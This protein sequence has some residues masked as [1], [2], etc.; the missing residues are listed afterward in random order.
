MNPTILVSLSFFTCCLFLSGLA[1]AQRTCD[2]LIAA[3]LDRLLALY[4]GFHAAP[5]L[6][7]HEE[8]SAA[9]VAGELRSLGFTV[10]ERVGRYDSKDPTCF[11]V[12]GVL[13]NGA[14]PTVLV[15]AD[16]DALPVTEMTGLPYASGVTV[17]GEEGTETGLMHACGHDMHMTC[18]IGT[19]RILVALK[20]AWRGTLIMVAQPAE[21]T[22]AGAKAML[23][24]GLYDRFGRPDYGLALHVDAALAAGTVGCSAGYAMA[25]VDTVDVTVR[26]VGGHGAYPHTTKD[27]VVM[28]AQFVLNLQT[29][30]SREVS[31][32]DTAVVTVGSIHGGTKHNIIPDAVHLQLTVR[33]YR[34][35]VRQQV[36]SSLRRIAEGIA[37]G[38]GVPE[39]RFPTVVVSK[40]RAVP[41]LYNDP[42]LTGRLHKAWRQA[43]GAGNVMEHLPVMA[44]EDF[45]HYSLAGHEIPTCLFWLGAVDPAKV[46]ASR[47]DGKPLPSLHSPFFAPT[48]KPTIRTGIDAMASAVL[49]LL[50]AGA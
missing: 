7:F 2:E 45:A 15:R 41:A 30:V 11:G 31:P 4:K 23:R 50:A 49:E 12:V 36:L 13:E 34:D 46:E 17:T 27:P 25:S 10:F 9:L 16:M 8:R 42:D 48:P 18:F 14:G 22:G 21:E 24:D 19:A 32:L 47:R 38:A 28:A 3:E 29:I 33:A 6:S 35:A 1:Q 44:G 39:D 43:L 40:A 26:G 5:E 20:E 37:R